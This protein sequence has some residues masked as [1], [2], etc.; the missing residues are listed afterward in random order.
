MRATK[1][2]ALILSLVLATLCSAQNGPAR[3]EFEVASVRLVRMDR[4]QLPPSAFRTYPERI[5]YSYIPLGDLVRRAYDLPNYRI[6]WPERLVDIRREL[7]SIGAT[8]PK[9][10]RAVEIQE[11]L[12]GLLQDRLGLRTHWEAKTVPG[13]EANLAPAGVKMT[14]SKYDPADSVDPDG[15]QR[16]ALNRYVIDQGRDGWHITGVISIPQLLALFSTELGQPLI[17]N[18]HSSGYYDID[19]I[20]NRPWVP[21]TPPGAALRPAKPPS[22]K[23]PNRILSLPR[24]RNSWGSG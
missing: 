12:R 21:P 19:F 22:R 13:Y 16:G 20:W 1:A 10:T 2:S 14:A 23:C 17:D 6:S 18:T 7:Y 15:A 8:F 3:A 24:S 11:M 4:R 9:G 5:D